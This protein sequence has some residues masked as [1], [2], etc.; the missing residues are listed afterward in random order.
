MGGGKQVDYSA[1]TDDRLAVMAQ[2][3]D[4]VA[5]NTLASRYIKLKLKV[6]KSSYL[7][8]E[9]F[10]QEA[11]FGFMKAVKTFDSSRGV[12]FNAYAGKC[13]HNSM[14]SA[15][16]DPTPE[17]LVGDE[18]EINVPTETERDPLELIISNERLNEVLEECEVSLSRLEKTVVFLKASGMSYAEIGEKLNM[19]IKS[20]DNAVQRARKKLKSV[21]I[22]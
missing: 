6:N 9:D 10:L 1:L 8:V 22:V 7:E 11:M 17:I 4:E 2:G 21:F 3:G 18:S 15:F 13:M 5:F 12:P 16:V 20:V 19:D 14:A